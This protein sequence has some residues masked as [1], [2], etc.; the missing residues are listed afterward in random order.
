MK[1][2]LGL[3]T[4]AFTTLAVLTLPG[5][6]LISG[7]AKE[8][9][10]AANI[11]E[12]VLT[13]GAGVRT[14]PVCS[15]D[16]R[17]LAFTDETDGTHP[18]VYVMPSGGGTPKTLL[19]PDSTGVA[20]GWSP[21]SQSL[22]VLMM[23]D[24]RTRIRAY[25]LSGNVE[26]DIPALRKAAFV[27]LSPDGHR[28]LWRTLNGDSWDMGVSGEAD[29]TWHALEET[30]E[31][32]MDA[33]FGPGAG[34]VT[35]VRQATYNA[36]TSDLGIY[37]M[38]THAWSPL[39]LPKAQNKEPVWDP[40]KTLLAFISD[41]AGSGDLWIY[42]SKN[43]RLTQITRGPEEDADPVWA[44]D[45]ASVVLS[46]KVT[47]SHVFAGNPRT[48]EKVQLTDGE[49][50]DYFPRCSPDGRWVAFFRRQPP[51]GKESAETQL[52]VM[53]AAA[54]SSVTTLDLGNLTLTLGIWMFA[55]SPDGSNLVFT[56]D[57]GTGNVDLYSVSRQGGHPDRITLMPGLDAIPDWSPDGQQ[58]AYTRL[59]EGE[60]QIWSIP[61]TGGLPVQIS[62]HQGASEVSI[63]APDSDH[64]AYYCSQGDMNELRVTSLKHPEDNRVLYS[65]AGGILPAGWSSEGD[66]VLFFREGGK[67]WSIEAVPATGGTPVKVAN[68]ESGSNR[69]FAKFDPKYERMRERVFPGNLNV[70]TD[71][72]QIANLVRIDVSR[73]LT[74]GFQA[75]G[76]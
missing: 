5:V 11:R 55:W 61:A 35:L 33:C 3:S 45:G 67:S 34:D 19:P 40:G 63:W 71:G 70:F 72:E 53:P 32:E 42:D 73:L 14:Y 27:D 56:A 62:R 20:I 76:E 9:A 17:W 13:E 22:L 66:Q 46:R 41:R 59:A 10:V 36:P 8:H 21:D 54:G 57:D 4:P 69:F 28:F 50:R 24:S 23:V 16:G 25:S 38:K 47:S 65:T 18:T 68:G 30:S 37:S 64:L 74:Q 1:Q 48:F 52:C 6:L 44:P 7:C 58:I 75:A 15:P 49:A 2:P 51:A 12:T 31:W 60:T 39:P 29:S 26:R 43:T